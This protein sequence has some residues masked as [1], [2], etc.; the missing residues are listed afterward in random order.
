M[1]TVAL[2]GSL[3]G[4]R[5]SVWKAGDGWDPDGAAADL[6]RNVVMRRV[7][8]VRGR[9]RTGRG[10]A[11]AQENHSIVHLATWRFKKKSRKSYHGRNKSTSSQYFGYR[12]D[13]IEW[14]LHGFWTP[15][16]PMALN[17]GI[18]NRV[19]HTKMEVM[20]SCD[21]TS[22]AKRTGNKDVYQYVPNESTAKNKAKT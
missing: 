8:R 10:L 13:Q 9:R 7:G 12:P 3:A 19:A 5:R 22:A 14:L 2:R 18:E 11:L 4:A 21:S 15:I 17:Q 20:E 1:E 16:E 6:R